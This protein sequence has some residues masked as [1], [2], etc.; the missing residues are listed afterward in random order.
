[1]CIKLLTSSLSF[2]QTHVHAYQSPNTSKYPYISSYS[3][4]NS[5][6]GSAENL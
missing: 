3:K 4:P 5:F 1:M 2:I 6:F